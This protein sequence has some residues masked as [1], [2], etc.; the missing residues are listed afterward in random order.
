[1]IDLELGKADE[2]TGVRAALVMCL[3][4]CGTLFGRYVAAFNL[5]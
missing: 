4:D 2:V 3:P 1:M 5:L